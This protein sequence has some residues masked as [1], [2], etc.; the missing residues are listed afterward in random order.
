MPTRIRKLRTY[1]RKISTKAKMPVRRRNFTRAVRAVVARTGEIKRLQRSHQ[2]TA[3]L[4]S[5]ATPG[6]NIKVTDLIN[7]AS[8]DGYSQRDGHVIRGSGFR[9]AGQYRNDGNRVVYVRHLV[10]LCKNGSAQTTTPST[11]GFLEDNS[12]D[13]T[14]TTILN[15]FKRVNRDLFVPLYD[16][17]IKLGSDDATLVNQQVVN[18]CRLIRHWLPFKRLIRFNGS[19]AINPDSGRVILVTMCWTADNT[20]PNENVGIDITSDF[21]Y[22]EH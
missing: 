20:T 21:Y 14:A 16:K 11:T 17:I 12:G 19:S 3:N 15:L 10:L 13:I 8:G 18:R 1:K 7:I 5:I 22:R 9:I 2:Y 6:A 4:D